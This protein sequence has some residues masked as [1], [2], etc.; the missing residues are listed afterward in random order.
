MKYFR[1]K[2]LFV[3]WVPQGQGLPIDLKRDEFLIGGEVMSD[4]KA[5]QVPKV[6]FD[7]HDMERIQR[8][9]IR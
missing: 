4:G 8:I 7:K 1:V 2:V 5:I 6:L 3:F 9:E